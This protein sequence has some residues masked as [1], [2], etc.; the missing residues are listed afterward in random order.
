MKVQIRY[1]TLCD[2]DIN[3]W[4]ILIDGVEY[5]CSKIDINVPV[6]TTRDNVYDSNRK[7]IVNKHHIS[8]EANTIIWNG[9]EVKVL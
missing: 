5:V 2:D 3:Y 4:R 1:N 6:I 8:C 7:Q 9:T